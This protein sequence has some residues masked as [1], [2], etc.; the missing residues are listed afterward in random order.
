MSRLYAM[1]NGGF[2]KIVLLAAVLAL[3]TS[4]IAQST[5]AVKVGKYTNL[6]LPR[7]VSLKAQKVNMRVG[8]G[9]EYAVA[10]RYEKAGMPLE[11]IQ[12]FDNWRRVRDVAGDTGWIHKSLL[13]GSR[14]GITT[15]W[16]TG[17]GE[18]VGLYDEP[19]GEATRLAFLK[20]GVIGKLPECDGIWCRMEVQTPNG[21][22]LR[23]FV[24]QADLWGAYP[25]EQFD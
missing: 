21:R 10:W 12:E 11:I 22:T 1:A 5:G 3:P 24:S 23:G 13:S 4:A 19:A 25:D 16:Q 17:N 8:P 20:P 7:F 14:A 18:G 6:P 2:C 9:K 15:P